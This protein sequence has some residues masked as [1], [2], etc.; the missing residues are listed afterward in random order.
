MLAEQG[1]EEFVTA[2]LERIRV[3][4]TGA[5]RQERAYERDGVDGLRDLYLSGMTGD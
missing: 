2:H 3:D 5:E 4:G 1:D